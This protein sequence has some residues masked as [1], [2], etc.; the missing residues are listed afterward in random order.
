MTTSWHCGTVCG[1]QLSLAWGVTYKS[2]GNRLHICTWGPGPFSLMGVQPQ[3][4]SRKCAMNALSTPRGAVGWGPT[5]LSPSRVPGLWYPGMAP[6][7]S[8]LNTQFVYDI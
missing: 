1:L 8:K 6:N 7:P 4:L 2:E 3:S 5:G